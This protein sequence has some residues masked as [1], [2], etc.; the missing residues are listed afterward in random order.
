MFKNF[1][2]PLGNL[3]KILWIIF[4]TLES[5]YFKQFSSQN[6]AS[7]IFTKVRT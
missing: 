3:I 6:D 4:K 1:N 7:I 2:M 5:S